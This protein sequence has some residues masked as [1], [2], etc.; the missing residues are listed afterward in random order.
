VFLRAESKAVHINTLIRVAGVGLVRLNPREVRTFTLRE[1]VLAVK[2]ELSSDN[3]V[4]APAVHVQRGL[5]EHKGTGI[6]D[7]RVVKVGTIVITIVRNIIATKVGLIVGIARSVPVPSEICVGTSRLVIK[8]TS[9]LEKTTGINVSA[10]ISSDSSGT[11]E[12]MDSVGKSINGISVVE[13]LSTK[14]LEKEGIASQGRAV[15]N[16]LI[17]L[18]NPDELLHGVVEV[19]LDLVGRRTNRL[20]TS[21]LE[22]SNQVLMGILGHSAAL[23]SVQ[24]HV[25]NIQRSSYQRLIVSNGGRNRATNRVLSITRI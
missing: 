20:I 1:A 14:Y 12:S 5:R 24:K 25:I 6:R 7:T 23:I 8:S 11:S 4:L 22:L 17:G 19:K 3:R 9:I 2:L 10:R 18:Y 15:V 21:E 13:G 16:V